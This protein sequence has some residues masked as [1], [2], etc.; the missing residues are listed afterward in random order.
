[1]TTRLA[2]EEPSEAVI[3][4]EHMV[5]RLR[6]IGGDARTSVSEAY[7]PVTFAA[8]LF[9]SLA[10]LFILALTSFWSAGDILTSRTGA[11]VRP[12]PNETRAVVC[13]VLYV[14][15]VIAAESL[16]RRFRDF[17]G[18]IITIALHKY[19]IDNPVREP[20]SQ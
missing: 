9:I 14:A 3:A 15:V 11:L 6:T 1:M 19:M 10:C 16:R 7:E 2:V 20:V 8:S 17:S 12:L 5:A 13:V 4:H 18:N